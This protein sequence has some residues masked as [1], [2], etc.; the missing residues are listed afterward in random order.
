[1]ALLDV[2]PY[3]KQYYE[4]ILKPFLPEKFIDCHTHVWLMEHDPNKTLRSGTQNWPGLVAKENSIEDLNETNRLLFPDNKVI[5]V[6]YGDCAVSIDRKAVNQYVV[7]K[8]I[9]NDFPALYLCH[10]DTPA[11]ELERIILENPVF[12]GIKVY[13]QFAPGYLPADEIRIYDFLTKEHLAVCDKHGWVV[14]LHIARPKRLADPVNYIQLLEI[15]QNYPNLQLIVAHLGRAYANEDVGNALDY[16]KNTQ[17]T[18]WDFTANTNDWVME[19]V[20]KYFGPER[21]IYGSDFPI[22]RMKARRTVEN[23]VY[24]N[25]IPQGQFPYESVKNDAHMREI[26]YPE[27]EKITF[28]IYEEMNACRLACQRLGLG[29]ADVE[30][31]FYSNSAR[32]FG[33]K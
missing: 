25:E 9:A 31:I 26:P 16:L 22:F 15:E 20:M 23:G 4:E 6:L 11:E 1:M 21:F 2:K 8:A 10:P 19:Q 7:D 12:K 28:F 27:A 29:K 13:L 18:V 14:Q 32:I 30:K 24:I 17:K 5:S 33:V 3:D